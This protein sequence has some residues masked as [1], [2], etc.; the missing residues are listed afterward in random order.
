MNTQVIAPRAVSPTRPMFWSVRRELWENR[1]IFIAPLCAAG[2]VIF[3]TFIGS[4]HS[5]ERRRA[6]LLL[7]PALQRAAIERPY[8]MVAVMFLFLAFIVGVFYCLDAL[9]G[10]RRDRTILFWKSLPVSDLTTVLSKAS[11]PLVVLPLLTFAITIAV[12][13]VILL[14][15][16]ATLVLS[17]MSATTSAQLS[18]LQR[19]VMLFYGLIVMALWH[20]PIY[21]WLLLV[22]G[23]ARRAAF[24]WA[25]LPLIAIQIFEKIAF[26]TSYF[27]ALLN[28]HFIG[29]LSGA[30][31]PAGRGHFT[32]KPLAA[33]DPGAAL[34]TPDLWLGL[35][36]ATLLIAGAVRLRRYREPL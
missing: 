33:L 26:G 12:Q 15:S 24:L 32:M 20:A 10:E 17:G 13:L 9:H 16:N 22:S 2:V 25:F 6:A 7:D 8:D 29:W 23:W 31:V 19:S 35:T 5:A 28:P 1:S 36:V 18:F 4:F 27:A 3:S 14:I 11:I 34:W 30:F 21:G